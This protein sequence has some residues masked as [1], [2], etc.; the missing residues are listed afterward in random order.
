VD[1]TDDALFVRS[2]SASD[3]KVWRTPE[4]SAR[5]AQG[6]GGTETPPILACGLTPCQGPL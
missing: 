2:N 3:I 1:G 5:D 6:A 4:Q